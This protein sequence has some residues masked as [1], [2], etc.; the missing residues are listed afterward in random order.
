[1]PNVPSRPQPPPL[2]S[3]EAGE[4]RL[5]STM[6]HGGAVSM[7]HHAI[8][9]PSNCNGFDIVIGNPPYV[10]TSEKIYKDYYTFD[11]HEL[12]AYFFEKA[13]HLLVPN[14]ILSFITAS[15]WV[16]GLKFEKL[17]TFLEK[18]IQLLEYVNR[19]DDIFD[20]VKMPTA[21]MMGKKGIGNWSCSELNPNIKIIKKMQMGRKQLYQISQIQRGLE[22]ARGDVS[23][24]GDYPCITGTLVNKYRPHT[25]KY[26]SQTTLLANAKDEKYFTN[27]RILLR[28]TGSFLMA[29]YL[30]EHLYSN[31]SL[32]SILITDENYNTKFVLACLNSSLMQFYYQVKFKAETEL[33][34]KIRIAQAKLL[35]IPLATQ[36]QQAAVVSLVD[37]ILSAKRS[38]PKADTSAI[39]KQIDTIVYNLFDLSTDE[40]ALIEQCN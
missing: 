1:M 32:Y 3:G 7:P 29:L 14:G 11:C 9:R 16:K 33:F 25:I 30:N 35:P 24:K 38:D 36:E 21:T 20:K 6:K 17:R 34:P 28:E 15:L 5:P 22:I 8:Q 13:I 23:I 2:L 26:I 10:V 31:R 18:N 12:Y 39:E 4:L 40:I 37:K 19:G 27:E